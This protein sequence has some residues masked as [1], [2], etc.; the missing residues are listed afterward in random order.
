MRSLNP[1]FRFLLRALLLTAVLLPIWWLLLLNPML[2]ARR[3]SGE[4]L[5][6]A[7]SGGDAAYYIAERPGGEW[8]FRVPVPNRIL[9]DAGLSRPAGGFR[10]VRLILVRAVP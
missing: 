10:G 7:S 3:A 2:A 4:L 5:L 1:Q 8:E 9:A 6:R